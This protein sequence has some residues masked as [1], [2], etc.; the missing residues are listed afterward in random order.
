MGSRLRRTPWR[1][2]ANR[3]QALCARP[4]QKDEIRVAVLCAEV[5]KCNVLMISLGLGDYELRNNI[6]TSLVRRRI[7]G[8]PGLFTRTSR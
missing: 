1:V 6:L 3:R 8:C 2:L 5:R 7:W 4:I